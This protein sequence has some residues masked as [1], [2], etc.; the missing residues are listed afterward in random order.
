MTGLAA[1]LAEG[2]GADL[3]GRLGVA[4]SG[5]GDSM[6]LMHL[7]AGWAQARGADLAVVTV[8][9][10][11]RPEA[12]AEADFVARVAAGLGLSHDTLNWDGW[13][14]HGNLQDRAR[15][16]RQRLI[17]DWACRRR[18]GAVALGHTADDQAET[19]LMRLARGAG[20]DGLSG[21][22]PRRAAEGMLW[23]RPLLACR[24]AELR[25]YL[26]ELGQVWVEDPGNVDPRFARVRAR[27]ALTV[28]AP[29]GIEA[30]T[31]A[32]VCRNL[33]R[34]RDALDAH[35]EA[36]AR[37]VARI[38]GG[39]V[40]FDRAALDAL[41]G[42]TRRRL[43]RHAL[44]WVSGADYGPREGALE[45]TLAALADCPAATLHG[46]LMLADGPTLRIAREH[47]AVAAAETPTGAL[48]DG[49]WRFDGPHHAEL[50]LRALGEAGL[51][52]CPDWRATGRPRAAL[53]AQPGVWRGEKLVAA[54]LAGL[55]EGWRAWLA[56]GED[57]F[58]RL[59]DSH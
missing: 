8:D 51:A 27:A 57:S 10:G 18:I 52:A 5:G 59:V 20:V 23:L 41:P 30:A 19:F 43:M 15:R 7:M 16:A 21:M 54:P 34:A 47:R 11:L 45:E 55:S 35:A 24:R 14:G 50:T 42:E 32:G 39:D 36:A 49:R 58:F 3:P 9:H 46:C 29:L 40:V 56:T 4:V 26:E 17:A 22:A 44:V 1:A 38:D 37:R 48:W 31:L 13:D 2:L 12:A 6:A 53:V 33:A 25:S 28:L